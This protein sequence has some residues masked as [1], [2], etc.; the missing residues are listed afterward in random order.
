MGKRGPKAKSPYKWTGLRVGFRADDAALISAAAA[1]QGVRVSPFM[2][3]LIL[4]GIALGWTMPDSAKTRWSRDGTE[5]EPRW[6]RDGT[7]DRQASQLPQAPPGK[8]GV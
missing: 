1:A 2:R 3:W 4:R 7:N 8:S 6:N 5:V